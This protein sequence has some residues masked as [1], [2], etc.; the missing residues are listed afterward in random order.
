M[1]GVLIAFSKASFFKF[2]FRS[3]KGALLTYFDNLI[4]RAKVCLLS[5]AKDGK[6]IGIEIPANSASPSQKKETSHIPSA[7]KASEFRLPLNVRGL[8]LQRSH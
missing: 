5:M 7:G 1:A 3:T 2:I 8:L 6:M 4:K